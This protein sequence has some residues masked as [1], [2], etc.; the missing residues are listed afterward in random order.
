MALTVWAASVLAAP[1]ALMTYQGALTDAAGNPANGTYA[2]TF[3]MYQNPTGGGIRWTETI[4]S[5]EVTD[6]VFTVLLGGTTP[7][8]AGLV[9][10]NYLQVTVN[11]S[12]MMPRH[13]LTS[14]PY[15]LESANAADAAKLGGQAAAFYRNASNLSSG[16]LSI[17]RLPADGITS[18]K[19]KNGG[20]A[21]IDLANGAV[22]GD[23]IALGTTISGSVDGAILSA[24]NSSISISAALEGHSTAYTSQTCG[25]KGIGDSPS[26]YGVWGKATAAAGG[27]GVTG[28]SAGTNEGTG[29]VGEAVADSGITYGVRGKVLSPDGRALCAWSFYDSAYGLYVENGKAYF[30]DPVQMQSTLNVTGYATFA[31]GHG[32]L[33]ENYRGRDVEAGDVVVIGKGGVLVECAEEMDTTV[34]GI[35]STSPSMKINGR[36][37]DGDGTVPLALVGRVLCKVDASERPIQEGDLLVTSSTPGHAMKCARKHPPAGTVIG[38]AQEALDQGIGVIQVLVTLR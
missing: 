15:A 34:A 33:A 22:T 2:M 21:T 9:N 23:K 27:V 32:D 36:I 11:G 8:P 18:G 31:G 19:I 14:V 13:R 24:E 5:V 3:G 26:G 38:K 17:T 1:P 35:V 7:L 16:T 30:A 12:V 4:A 10:C 20:I 6:G 28:T 25:V 37:E 29:V